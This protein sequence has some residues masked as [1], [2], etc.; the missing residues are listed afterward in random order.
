MTRII[1]VMFDRSGEK[2]A[3]ERQARKAR[4]AMTRRKSRP[5][6]ILCCLIDTPDPGPGPAHAGLTATPAESPYTKGRS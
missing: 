1:R 3:K 5:G 6:S 2:A 4:E